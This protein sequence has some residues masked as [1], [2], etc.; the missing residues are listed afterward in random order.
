MRRRLF[1][2]CSALSLVLCLAAFVLGYRSHHAPPI[3]VEF[4]SK[5]ERWEFVLDRGELRLDNE[6]QL[7]VDEERRDAARLAFQYPWQWLTPD[8]RRVVEAWQ[9][10]SPEAQE[11]ARDKRHRDL[12]LKPEW[13]ERAAAAR[14]PRRRSQRYSNPATNLVLILSMLVL[15]AVWLGHTARAHR[16]RRAQVQAGLCLR[17]GYDLRATPDRCPECGTLAEAKGAAA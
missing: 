3:A 13:A 2:I 16:N 11:E 5:G 9:S 14:L 17:C 8:E 10:L 1:T 4:T 15:P 6:P 12:L 7:L